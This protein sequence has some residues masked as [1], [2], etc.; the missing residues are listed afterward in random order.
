[1][2]DDDLLDNQFHDVTV[3]LIGKEAQLVLDNKLVAN[4]VAS[5]DS[6]VLDVDSHG[7]FVGGSLSIENKVV[8]GFD[9]CLW[10]LQLNGY[11]VPF[12]NVE[13][14]IFASVVPSNGVV[15]TCPELTETAPLTFQEEEDSVLFHVVIVVFLLFIILLSVTLVVGSKL[16]NHYCLSRRGKF[17]IGHNISVD[18]HRRMRSHSRSISL[19]NVRPYHM[20]GGGES[21]NDE[22]SFHELRSLERPVT[23][24]QETMHLQSPLRN[25]KVK[26]T[27]DHHHEASVSQLSD[28]YTMSAA[29]A[30]DVTPH[31]RNLP[32]LH[33]QQ[34][35]SSTTALESSATHLLEEQQSP[36]IYERP[37]QRRQQQEQPEATVLSNGNIETQQHATAAAT[38]NDDAK[39][40][41]V[42]NF[43]TQKITAANEDVE[44]T[45]Y[46]ELRV[47]A[48]EG[49]FDPLGSI[50]S[51]YNMN[52]EDDDETISLQSF[53]HLGDY[54][55]RF[56][57]INRILQRQD[58]SAGDN[59]SVA[60]SSVVFSRER[61]QQEPFH[62]RDVRIV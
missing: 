43:I 18:I 48:E 1:M 45:N 9:G 58:S 4:T 38:T 42:S 20:D 37:I 19:E 11:S 57:K 59:V 32:T 54:G 40:N 35:T 39:L 33:E 60:T 44:N 12:S 22:F 17:V 36:R 25:G 52:M 53:S 23:D 2:Y 41:E 10:G 62:D 49:D 55:N 16:L 26:R 30:L 47:Y 50:G 34:A 61:L 24:L 29:S 51:L 21:D 13:H 3:T 5:G 27:P 28:A 14:E 56:Q 8:N 15:H 46:D 7:M 31:E 6:Q